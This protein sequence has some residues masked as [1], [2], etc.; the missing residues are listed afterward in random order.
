[1]Q[2]RGPIRIRDIHRAGL[3]LQQRADRRRVLFSG[4]FEER[5]LASRRAGFACKHG[6]QCDQPAFHYSFQLHLDV[7]HWRFRGGRLQPAFLQA[8]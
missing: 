3:L 1:V 5:R 8:A 6:E 2:W 4:G 7:S